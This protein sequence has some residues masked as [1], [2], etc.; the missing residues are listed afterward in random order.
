MLD[1]ELMLLPM[2]PHLNERIR[3]YIYHHAVV[4]AVAAFAFQV[5]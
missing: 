4:V 5:D 3:S 1:V 2:K